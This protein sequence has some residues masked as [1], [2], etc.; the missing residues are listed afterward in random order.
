MK[1]CNPLDCGYAHGGE[2]GTSCIGLQLHRPVLPTKLDPAVVVP[3][4]IENRGD[5]PSPTAPL[6][7]DFVLPNDGLLTLAV[8]TYKTHRALGR[9]K[10]LARAFLS[11]FRVPVQPV[12][13]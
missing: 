13:N 10:A 9:R 11:L 6:A 1:T 7:V 12:N 5:T 2:C 3:G 4:H 8:H